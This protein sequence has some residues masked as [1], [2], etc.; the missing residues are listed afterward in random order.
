M[1]ISS[2]ERE[3]LIG[4]ARL[5]SW[6]SLGWMALEGV[7]AVAA[8]VAAGSVALLGF[9][10][11][12]VIEGLASVIIIWRLRDSRKLSEH[13]EQRARKL[14]AISFFVLAPCIAWDAIRVLSDGQHPSTSWLGIGIA[15]SSIVLMPLLGRAKQQIGARLGSGAISAEGAQNLI[16]AY[17][18]AAVLAGLLA[19]TLLGIWW[20][21]SV[22]AL[23]IAALALNEGREA[24]EAED[25][26]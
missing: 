21:D 25:F 2:A 13:A 23:G 8:A 26:D 17:L 5:L 20:L 1:G 18:A 12:S 14:I 24:W 15:I 3:R 19:N 10:I 6:L 11:D 7:L 4:R 16:C 9:G 22:V